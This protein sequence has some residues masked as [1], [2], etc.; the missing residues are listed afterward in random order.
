MHFYHTINLYFNIEIKIFYFS[1]TLAACANL[2]G[3]RWAYFSVPGL[4]K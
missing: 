1:G 3:D 2:T 4:P